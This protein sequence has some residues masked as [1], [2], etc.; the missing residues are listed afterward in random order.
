MK[1]YDIDMVLEGM[2]LTNEQ[3]IE[4]SILCGCDFIKDKI[5]GLGPKNAIQFI[6]EFGTIEA[7]IKDL[8]RQKN[9]ARRGTRRVGTKGKS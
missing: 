8:K 4:V 7:M 2:G 6:K 3:F 1:I 9:R 5:K